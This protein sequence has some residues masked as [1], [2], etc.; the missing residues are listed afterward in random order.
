MESLLGEEIQESDE[1]SL[2]DGIGEF[3]NIITGSAKTIFSN[4]DLKVLFDLPKTYTS[5]S[6]T[7]E[8]IGGNSGVWI[9]MQL[10][11]KA[12]YMFITK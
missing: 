1:N 3:C 6:K 12:F 11:S 7:R 5:L 10:D 2:Q 9:N 8:Y 4:K